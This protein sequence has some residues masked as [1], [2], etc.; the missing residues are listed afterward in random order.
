[1]AT[2]RLRARAGAGFTLLELTIVIA[3]VA[4]V[5][6]LVAPRV[7]SL[8]TAG[9]TRATLNRLVAAVGSARALARSR[10]EDLVVGLDPESRDVSVASANPDASSSGTRPGAAGPGS[11]KPGATRTGAGNAVSADAYSVTLGVGAFRVTK[12]E[13]GDVSG[14]NDPRAP[15]GETLAVF[16]ADGT[17]S[18]GSADLDVNGRKDT[19]RV[20]ADG[21]VTLGERDPNANEPARWK[22]GDL[23]SRT[24]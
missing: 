11:A 10:G 24:S 5:A 8:R 1:M 17:A 16:Y 4:M 7:L 20:K 14:T 2:G 13:R 12:V 3:I 23:E 21:S 22:A 15:K 18:P 19:L 6:A 9:E